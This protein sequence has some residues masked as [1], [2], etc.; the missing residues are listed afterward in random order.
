MSRAQR[1]IQHIARLLNR[2]AEGFIPHDID[3]YLVPDAQRVIESA[4]TLLRI[5]NAQEEGIYEN[6][7]AT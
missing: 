4:E 1:E 7:G 3:R 5:H 2:I 6:A